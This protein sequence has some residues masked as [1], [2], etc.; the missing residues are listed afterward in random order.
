MPQYSLRE[1]TVKIAAQI[2]DGQIEEAIAHTRHILSRYPRYLPAYSLLARASMEKGDFSHASH[3]FQTILSANPED[4]DAWMNLAQLSDDLGEIEQA[5]WYMERAF[6]IEPGNSRVRERLRQLYNQRDGVERGRIKLTPAA[7]ART[8]IR[9]GSFRRA[10][11]KLQRILRT[12]PNLSP[13]QTAALE[14]T[15]AKALWN[16]KGKTSLAN[17]VC[18]SLLQKLPRCFQ[19]NLIRAQIY[20][21]AGQAKEAAPYLDIAR[22]LDPEGEFAFKLL[23]PQSPLP[24]TRIEIPYLDY[25]PKQ[26]KPLE[27]VPTQ[28]EDTRWLDNL[29]QGAQPGAKPAP[30][31]DTVS[32]IEQAPQA[33][34]STAPQPELA[35]PDEREAVTS[36]ELAVPAWLRE[37]QQE[38]TQ[39]TDTQENLDW[40]DESE[41]E[42]DEAGI[43]TAL[44]QSGASEISD[45]LEGLMPMSDEPD[46]GEPASLAERQT[47]VAPEVPEWLLDLG[48]EVEPAED[49]LETGG[50]LSSDHEPEPEI[51]DW[52]QLLD[53]TEEQAAPSRIDSEPI[54]APPEPKP[55]GEREAAWAELDLSDDPDRPA[56]LKELQAEIAGMPSISP[57]TR[58]LD[59]RVPASEL[60][61]EPR[62]GEGEQEDYEWL[63]DLGISELPEEEPA[64][65]PTP[66]D[67]LPD[68][69]LQLRDQTSAEVSTPLEPE[70]AEPEATIVEPELELDELELEASAILETDFDL[71]AQ[72]LDQELPEW[73]QSLETESELEL[74]TGPVGDLEIE[75]APDWLSESEEEPVST[76]P[77]DQM[78]DWLSRLQE[79]EAV[80]SDELELAEPEPQLA[81]EADHL[82]WLQELASTSDE[83]TLE[84]TPVLAV[85][86]I[87]PEQPPREAP[88]PTFDV[89]RDLEERPESAEVPVAPKITAPLVRAQ[90][91]VYAGTL[92]GSAQRY[93]SL[94]ARGDVQEELIAELE[95]AV[96][97]HPEHSGLQR[98]LG[99]AYMRF[100]RLGEALEAYRAALR[101]L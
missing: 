100:D 85:E 62:A 93:E 42:L 34:S 65:E 9:S 53:Q 39:D 96:Q 22:Q 48:Q 73:L 95:G 92:D 29:G 98:V 91:P 75:Q 69:L 19:A 88:A 45:L 35:L 67:E 78:P 70:P 89:E 30:G 27:P 24:Q 82:E 7:L 99:D 13:L 56:W 11:Q 101:K 38:G 80:P 90:P 66:E 60:P 74:E 41:D 97:A 86:T 47:M 63:A 72:E 68:W 12:E 1:Y 46:Q 64:L 21:G 71:E 10:S 36:A 3:F 94:I 84:P 31:R 83:G 18:G 55:T 59:R 16:Q 17:D 54:P 26:T 40:L 28:Q 44:P 87:E 77:I 14:V 4:A 57:G 2:Q 20:A 51:P 15:L 25:Q 52:L 61:Q 23:G 81:T 58:P 76:V 8:Q 50:L 37:I 5:V 79:T 6:E 49:E 43:G 32:E 33:P